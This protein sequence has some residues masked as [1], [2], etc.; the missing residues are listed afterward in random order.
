MTNEDYIHFMCNLEN[1]RNCEACPECMTHYDN[2]IAVTL[3]CGQF[4]CWVE[5]TCDKKED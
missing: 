3:P 4:H 1:I 5:L 2:E